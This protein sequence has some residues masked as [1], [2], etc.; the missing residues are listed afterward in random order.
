MKGRTVNTRADVRIARQDY[1]QARAESRRL[2]KLVASSMKRESKAFERL[3]LMLGAPAIG[4]FVRYTVKHQRGLGSSLVKTSIR[5]GIVKQ[6][7]PGFG[8]DPWRATLTRV[9]ANGKTCDFRDWIYSSQVE[10]HGRTF[11]EVKA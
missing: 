9:A 4:R 6:L 1:T 2:S 11:A 5:Y 10:Q 3:A 7:S 8:G